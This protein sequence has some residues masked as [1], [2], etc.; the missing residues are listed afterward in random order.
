MRCTLPPAFV[1]PHPFGAA[2]PNYPP[3]RGLLGET[4]LPRVG[5]AICA[6]HYLEHQLREPQG[7]LLLAELQ[8]AASGPADADKPAAGAA[9]DG[10]SA[11]AAA[12][13]AAGGVAP[14]GGEP[15]GWRRSPLGKAAV[16]A[17]VEGGKASEG[18]ARSL[19]A[20]LEREA[21]DFGALRK[22]WAYKL[23]K[24]A[25]EAFHQL[26]A[27]Y[28]CVPRRCWA[29]RGEAGRGREGRALPVVPPAC[30]PA[31]VGRSCGG[32]AASSND[33][34]S[35]ALSA[36]THPL[37]CPPAGETPAPSPQVG[38][39]ACRR[40]SWQRAPRPPA[41]PRRR[42]PCC[43]RP[44]ACSSCC[45]RWHS[46]WTLWSSGARAGLLAG[47]RGACYLRQSRRGV[48]ALARN[49]NLSFDVLELLLPPSCRDVWKGVA[50]AV[51]YAFYN[52]V[53]TEALFSAE[54]GGVGWHA[55]QLNGAEC[56][57]RKAGLCAALCPLAW[58]LVLTRQQYPR[59]CSACFA[60][61][62]GPPGRRPV[63][64]VFC[65]VWRIHLSPRW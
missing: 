5:A 37:P 62:C 31:G 58:P 22:Q 46:T 26:F 3:C 47:S 32:V 9:A 16:G 24:Q 61:G 6:A 55:R 56:W 21:A 8:D 38:R 44:T 19:V 40:S 30:C 57:C 63:R 25:V 42:L 34:L 50:L 51:N 14:A 52:E 10:A 39:R 36:L 65:C 28:K 27:P 33:T 7:V 4:W 2:H 18:Q 1:P 64:C 23:A 48:L 20:L 15:G 29:G 45:A 60:T 12:N 11:V 17:A 49:P 13:G 43:R 41:P 54:V 35:S 59:P 53:A